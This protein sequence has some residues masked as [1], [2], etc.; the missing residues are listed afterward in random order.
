MH[1]SKKPGTYIY[2]EQATVCDPDPWRQLASQLKNKRSP[3]YTSDDGWNAMPKQHKG[4]TFISDLQ[5]KHV[6]NFISVTRVNGTR[7]SLELAHGQ[8]SKHVT[9]D[10][11][12][13][14]LHNFEFQTLHS[15]CLGVVHHLF[16]ASFAMEKKINKCLVM[17]LGTCDLYIKTLLHVP[18]YRHDHNLPVL[19]GCSTLQHPL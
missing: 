17:S 19:D 7:H 4:D 13:E 11:L 15:S 9:N 8:K 5:L 1:E 16:S 6:T 2:T 12:L 3:N 18:R 14:T 10:K